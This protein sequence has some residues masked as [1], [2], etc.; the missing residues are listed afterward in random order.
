MRFRRM[1]PGEFP[2]IISVYESR[3]P[4]ATGLVC[5]NTERWE[6]FKRSRNP[7]FYWLVA[8][9]KGRVVAYTA[10]TLDKVICDVG[11]IVWRPEYDGTG[12]GDRMLQEAF[13]RA[14]KMKPALINM[15]GMAGS[16]TM[17]A[18][19]PKAFKPHEVTGIFMAGVVDAGVFMRDL[20][21]ILDK[22]VKE[23][24]CLHIGGRSFVYGQKM[25]KMTCAWTDANTV[26][27]FIFGSKSLDKEIRNGRVRYIPKNREA[28]ETLTAAFP[29]RRFWIE[30]GW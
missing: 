27:G 8:E 5:R 17:S 4:E 12:L 15:W 25:G 7:K 13:N 20:R 3:F 26:L 6:L 30:D 22:R 23:K 29:E 10:W 19:R 9:D 11:E 24:L 21:R 28:M 14:M 16:L 1:R 2:Q 18:R